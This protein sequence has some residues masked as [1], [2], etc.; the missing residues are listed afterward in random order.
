M[1]SS[2]A[3][4]LVSVKLSGA[5]AAP[6][7]VP[8]KLTLSGAAVST[9]GAAPDAA[10]VIATRTTDDPPAT[11]V[12]SAT[13]FSAIHIPAM[14]TPHFHRDVRPSRR[15]KLHRRGGNCNAYV[16][17]LDHLLEKVRPLKGSEGSPGSGAAETGNARYEHPLVDPQL[18]QT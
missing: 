9:G 14:R 12:A 3:L 18:E 8:G 17:G 1:V 4:L 13:F 16:L 11:S 2:L 10:P 7:V 5:D 6:S 15:G